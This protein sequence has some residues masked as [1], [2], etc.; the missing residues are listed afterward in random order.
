M[1]LLTGASKGI[2]H[3]I[4][5]KLVATTDEKIIALYNSTRPDLK[6]PNVEWCKVDLSKF[7]E[8]ETLID[9]KTDELINVKFINC[10]GINHNAMTHKFP[11]EQWNNLIQ[12]NLTST[13]FICKLLLPFMRQQEYGKIVF[14]SSIVAQT[15]VVGSSA[16]AA[17]KAGLWGLMKTI[18]QENA[19]KHI[20]CNTL[21]LGYFNIGI[22]REVPEKMLEEIKNRIPNKTLGDP[23]DIFRTIELLMQSAYIN[24]SSIDINGGLYLS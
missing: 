21:N 10:A 4:L 9:S 16:Y 11:E 22:I 18:V 24:G 13:F 14:I 12:V 8:I 5:E 20:T 17:S 3:Y 1:Y 23:E 15:G 7:N 2:G 19:S 6:H